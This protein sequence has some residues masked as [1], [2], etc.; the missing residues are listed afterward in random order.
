MTSSAKRSKR[1]PIHNTQQGKDEPTT[2]T[3]QNRIL[4]M[5]GNPKRLKFVIKDRHVEVR[6]QINKKPTSLWKEPKLSSVIRYT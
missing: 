4:E 2:L 6:G 5:L 3:S 1:L